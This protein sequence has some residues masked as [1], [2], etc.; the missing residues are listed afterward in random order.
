[1]RFKTNVAS[2]ILYS[3]S[4]LCQSNG[5]ESRGIGHFTD[6]A[7]FPAAI[8]R[9]T[10]DGKSEVAGGLSLADNSKLQN[11][12]KRGHNIDVLYPG[13]VANEHAVVTSCDLKGVCDLSITEEDV[14]TDVVYSIGNPCWVDHR[15]YFPGTA[16][17]SVT[18]DTVYS[19]TGPSWIDFQEED[20]SPTTVSLSCYIPGEKLTSY[21][22]DS[23]LVPLTTVSERFRPGYVDFIGPSK[24]VLVHKSQDRDVLP[25][26]VKLF[27]SVLGFST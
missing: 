17:K 13:E 3:Y 19:I 5:L 1:M 22:T 14:T 11:S 4:E 24:T 27:T 2:I 26:P 16:E 18:T 23:I 10:S 8:S 25:S 21:P 12:P 6:N 9:E 7:D 15:I 20:Y